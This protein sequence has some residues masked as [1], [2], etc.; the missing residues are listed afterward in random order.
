[1]TDRTSFL[2]LKVIASEESNIYVVF[3][4]FER[5]QQRVYGGGTLSMSYTNSSAGESFQQSDPTTSDKNLIEMY[6]KLL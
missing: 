5:S 4:R 3:P 1:M 2:R 6:S